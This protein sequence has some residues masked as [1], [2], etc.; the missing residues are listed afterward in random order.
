MRE[1]GGKRVG[2]DTEVRIRG[3]YKGSYKKLERRFI[4]GL[5]RLKRGNEGSGLGWVNT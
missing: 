1:G 3:K 5:D 2:E 4:M